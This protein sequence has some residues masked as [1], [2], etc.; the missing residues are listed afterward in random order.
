MIDVTAAVII[1]NQKLLIAQRKE[2]DQLARYIGWICEKKND[3][4]LKGIVIANSY[5]LLIAMKIP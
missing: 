2:D 1:E 4:N 3:N 5:D